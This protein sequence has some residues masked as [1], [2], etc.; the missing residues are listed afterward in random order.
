MKRIEIELPLPRIKKQIVSLNV[1]RN[2]NFWLKS[3]AKKDYAQIVNL[4][5]RPFRRIKFDTP[6]ITYTLYNKTKR[7]RDLS[8]FCS[9]IDKF[10]CDSLVDMKMIVDD[11][12]THLKEI[13]YRF[14]G[15]GVD[16]VII[17]VRESK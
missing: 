10:F 17:E 3:K 14:G 5:L 11:D 12:C 15:Y 8:N 4:K 16:K 1:Y 9:I 6:V 13:D 7:R 2:L